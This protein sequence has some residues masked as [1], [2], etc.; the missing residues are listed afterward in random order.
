MKT[1][2]KL[3]SLKYVSILNI[4]AT[5]NTRVLECCHWKND[6]TLLIS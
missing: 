3:Q 6:Q 5:L 1:V 2:T 4:T